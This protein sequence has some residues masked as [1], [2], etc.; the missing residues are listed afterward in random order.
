MSRMI[1]YKTRAETKRIILHDSHTQPDF[2][3]VE[4]VTRWKALAWDGGLKMGLLGIGYHF[5]LERDGHVEE[6]RDRHLIGTHT[7][8]HNMDSIGI[9]L[10]GGREHGDYLGHDNFT[11]DQYRSL[12]ELLSELRQQYGP[13]PILG[14]SEVQRYRNRS[15]PNCPPIEMDDLRQDFEVFS[16]IRSRKEAAL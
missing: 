5:I 9:C 2:G 15:L 10:V 13:I 16:I 3:K 7:P 12:L 11:E 14:H 6:T 4:D 8:G 1:R